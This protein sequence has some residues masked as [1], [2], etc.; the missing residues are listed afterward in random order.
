MKVVLAVVLAKWPHAAAGHTV[1]TMNW[2]LSFRELGCDVWLVEEI[3]SDQCEPPN[4][5]C[6]RSPQEEF[7]HATAEEFGFAERQCLLVDGRSPDL[8]A[9]REFAAK[10]DL[11]LNYSGQFRGLAFL[12]SR[13]R[14]FYLD[15]DPAFTQLWAATCGVDMN[16]AGHDKFL[17][18]GT[19]LNDTEGLVPDTGQ[20]W[21]PTCPPVAAATWQAR[22]ARTNHRGAPSGELSGPVPSPEPA[23]AWTTVSH[24]YGYNDLPWAG[25]TYCGKRESLLA[26][27]TLPALIPSPAAIATDL[28][29]EWSDYTDF[30]DAGWQILPSSDICRDVDT[31]LRFIATSRGEIGIAKQGY[32][33]SRC[34]WISDR[35]VTYLSLGRPV[36]LHDTG[37]PGSVEPAPGFLPFS[38]VEEAAQ[39]IQN[40]ESDYATHS[41]GA[42]ELARTCFSAQTVLGPLLAACRT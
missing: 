41:T 29:P 35:S 9:F 39:A 37:W 23:R 27:R 10:A 31:Y 30:A 17:T 14:K 15:V 36:V 33:I 16:F 6:H 1:S 12:G 13:T 22:L 18:V 24:W 32:V 7:W 26:M 19:R 40:I 11:F 3:S 4:P 5:G 28:K 2:A 8:E 20:T 42:F 21:I 38:N 34:G 25:R